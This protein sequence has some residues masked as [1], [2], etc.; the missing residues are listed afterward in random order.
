MRW[1]RW[2]LL[3]KKINNKLSF[4]F[5]KPEH[6]PGFLLWQSTMVWQRRIKKALDPFQ[7]SHA[8]F[9]ILAILLWLDETQ[10]ESTQATI[11]SLSKLDKMTVSKSLKVLGEQGYVK[12]KE[13]AQDTRV[14]SIRL[15]DKG[16]NLTKEMV[17]LV[18][19]LD[20]DFFSVLNHQ[21]NTQLNG[22]LNKLACDQLL[23]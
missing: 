21:E 13:H 8:Q 18:E 12:R 23:S 17:P 7:I 22:I 4:G 15:T 14:K 5:E 19:G 9:V 11:V 6:S 20:A 3:P 16:K 2:W 1:M 10:S